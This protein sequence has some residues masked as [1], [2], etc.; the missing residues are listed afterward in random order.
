[1]DAPRRSVDGPATGAGA[2]A[3][4]GRQGGRGSLLLALAHALDLRDRALQALERGLGDLIVAVAQLSELLAELE[5]AALEG[6][7]RGGELRDELEH[8]LRRLREVEV[9]ERLAH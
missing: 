1:M 2:S 4:V 5:E 6:V 7:V 9:V 3:Q 8:L